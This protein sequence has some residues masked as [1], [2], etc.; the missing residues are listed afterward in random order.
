MSRSTIYNNNNIYTVIFIILYC[1]QNIDCDFTL[2]VYTS[3]KLNSIQ[4]IILPFKLTESSISEED[5]EGMVEWLKHHVEPLHKV[6]EFMGK[7]SVKRA[8]TTGTLWSTGGCY[9]ERAP[10]ANWYTGMVSISCQSTQST[11]VGSACVCPIAYSIDSLIQLNFLP[12]QNWEIRRPPP[13]I[14]WSHFADKL[15]ITFL[16]QC[17][18]FFA[19]YHIGC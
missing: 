11:K 4:F 13:L 17:F 5:Y 12:W 18:R 6:K 15:S 19:E 10:K 1:W 9:S 14:F 2:C 16:I 3:I 7:T 8:S